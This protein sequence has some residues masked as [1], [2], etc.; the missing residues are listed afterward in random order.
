MATN[1]TDVILLI[2][3]LL[4]HCD[5]LRQEVINVRKSIGSTDL[6]SDLVYDIRDYPA[7]LAFKDFL[8]LHYD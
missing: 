7:Y 4:D 3:A 1:E 6:Y 8:N 2:Q 5:E